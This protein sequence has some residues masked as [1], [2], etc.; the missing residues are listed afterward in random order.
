MAEVM[1]RQAWFLLD[2]VSP[3]QFGKESL[4]MA[5][6]FARAGEAL[7]IGSMAGATGPATPAGTLALQKAE[8]LASL[9]LIF[10]LT[11]GYRYDIYNSG[12][13]SIDPRAMVCSFGSRNQALFGIRMAQLGRF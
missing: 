6:I 10:A 3:L 13:H 9:F 8:L 5:L 7:Y 12:P 2:P 1:G 11:R 4:E